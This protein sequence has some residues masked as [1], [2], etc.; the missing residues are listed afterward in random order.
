MG[1][2]APSTL[3]SRDEIPSGFRREKSLL[4]PLPVRSN[5]TG[6][7]FAKRRGRRPQIPFC[8]P[9]VRHRGTRRV[10][11]RLQAV[12]ATAP[13][14][15]SPSAP[16]E[17]KIQKERRPHCRHQN[18]RREFGG[19]KERSCREV[20]QHDEE[21]APEDTDGIKASDVMPDRPPCDMR[22]D[23]PDKAQKSRK[24][25]DGARQKTCKQQSAEPQGADGN[26]ETESDIVAVCSRSPATASR[27]RHRKYLRFW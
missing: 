3:P 23:Q 19:R 20:G 6:F 13:D 4:P 2:D 16:P 25:H 14:L 12:P 9:S 7:H 27:I 17:Q 21:G 15:F 5:A 1:F 22:N 8:P 10:P 26:A 11:F 18:S 24:R